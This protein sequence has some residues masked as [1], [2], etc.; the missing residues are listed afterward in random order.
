MKLHVLILFILGIRPLVIKAARCRLDPPSDPSNL[1]HPLPTHSFKPC[2]NKVPEDQAWACEDPSVT[3]PTVECLAA[4]MLTCG[5]IG[6][7]DV[8]SVFWSYGATTADMEHF[9]DQLTPPGS[10]YY[11][12]LDQE[13]SDRV[14]TRFNLHAS[15]ERNERFVQRASQAMASISRGEVFLVLLQRQG[16]YGGVGIFQDPKPNDHL[17]NI[18]TE[19][20]FP[21]LQRNPAVTRI[22]S[23][24][25]SN[26]FHQDV[27]WANGVPGVPLLPPSTANT[28]PVPPVP[29]SFGR[30]DGT[31]TDTPVSDDCDASS[32]ASNAPPSSVPPSN[33]PA[34]TSPPSATTP[35]CVLRNQDPDQGITQAFCLC[36]GSATL[37]PLSVPN[38]GHQSDSCA[39]T[40]VPATAKETVTT[41][42]STYTRNCNVCTRVEFNAP[43]CT[44]VPKCTPTKAEIHVQAGSSAVHVGTL[45]G[46]ALYT[47]V[48]SALEKLCP[49]VTQSQSSTAC[50]TNS[51]KIPKIDYI[52]GDTLDKAGQL[53]V[54]VESSSYNTT[55]LRDAMIK[56][57][58]LTAQKGSEGSKSCSNHTYHALV[59]RDTPSSWLS[60]PRD[61]LAGYK[62]DRPQE[63]KHDALLCKTAA[64]A[65]VQ[66]F[67][68]EWRLAEHAGA[69]SWIDANWEFK[70]EPGGDFLCDFLE[71]IEIGITAL[72]PEF[73]AADVAALP[74]VQALCEQAFN[75][76]G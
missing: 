15:F 24:D 61:R 19:N 21:T 69:Q 76:G 34:I 43:S 63:V 17:T 54:K 6:S 41:L 18:W 67:S 10:C 57:A 71:A 56:S 46:T 74:E 16:Q 26:N 36:D 70:V 58:A 7:D 2:V 11:D 28:D 62:R 44:S 14:F 50:K 75:N 48:S 23:V 31:G 72:A 27:D 42:A 66:Y 33:S 68:P 51:V 1:R 8:R 52:N 37:S 73:V 39:Y 9:R 4:D 32:T 47:S 25:V 65:G 59:K 55:S 38:T 12:L 60:S 40:T 64:F 30:R 22:I 49:T 3:F 35:S 5:N 13:Y 20:E 45:T 29:G 53:V